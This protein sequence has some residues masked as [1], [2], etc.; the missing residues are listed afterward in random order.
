MDKLILAG[1]GTFQVVS[2]KAR[3]GGIIQMP[4]KKVPKFVARKTLKEKI[5]LRR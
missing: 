2:K 4:A 1:F 5:S 3:T